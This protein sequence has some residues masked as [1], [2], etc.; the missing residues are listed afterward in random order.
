MLDDISL[1]ITTPKFGLQSTTKRT[2]TPLFLIS[3]QLDVWN[4]SVLIISVMKNIEKKNQNW[5]TVLHEAP[6]NKRQ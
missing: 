5:L 4:H 3:M 1:Y 2:E 6:W